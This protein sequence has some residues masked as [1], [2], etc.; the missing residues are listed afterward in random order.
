M[1]SFETLMRWIQTIKDVNILFMGSI[2]KVY[3][4]YIP[5][6][7]THTHTHTHTHTVWIRAHQFGNCRKQ[8]RPSRE[9]NGAT[10]KWRKGQKG[11]QYNKLPCL[12]P[13][14]LHYTQVANKYNHPYVETSA[15]S[16]KNVK[17]VCDTNGPSVSCACLHTSKLSIYYG[18]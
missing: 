11:T 12:L 2:F 5:I 8:T 6:C 7:T 17:K 13:F 9:Q 10:I 16:G 14:A 15:A 1:E 18:Q 4:N 3:C